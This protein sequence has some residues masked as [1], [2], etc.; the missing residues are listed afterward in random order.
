MRYWSTREDVEVRRTG[1]DMGKGTGSAP[2]N[3]P[4]PRT[5]NS[6]RSI[7]EEECSEAGAPEPPP[8]NGLDGGY[9]VRPGRG[10][11]LAGSGSATS[12]AWCL[13][14][15]CSKLSLFTKDAAKNEYGRQAAPPSY[16]GIRYIRPWTR[17][18]HMTLE[19]QP[20]V[21]PPGPSASRRPADG[22]ASGTRPP[23][24]TPRPP[25]RPAQLQSR[26]TELAGTWEGQRRLDVGPFL[27]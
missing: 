17:N 6:A 1:R 8:D 13:A 18:S 27:P 23:S 14:S 7:W 22:E 2:T 24:K 25:Q 11:R 16:F 5:A 21:P 10:S 4:T 12:S 19:P 26:H 3:A 20:T 15:C 9:G